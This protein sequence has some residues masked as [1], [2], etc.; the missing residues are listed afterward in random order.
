MK[1]LY[2]SA[3]M[4]KYSY[5]NFSPIGQTIFIKEKYLYDEYKWSKHIILEIELLVYTGKHILETIL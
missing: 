4:L 5:S 2:S 3:K 1:K